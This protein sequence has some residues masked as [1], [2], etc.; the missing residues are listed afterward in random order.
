MFASLQAS[1]SSTSTSSGTASDPKA[2]ADGRVSDVRGSGRVSSPSSMARSASRASS[3]TSSLTGTSSRPAFGSGVT[4][5][6]P[7]STT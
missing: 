2:C 4:V 5:A 6:A 7:L 1:R 3:T